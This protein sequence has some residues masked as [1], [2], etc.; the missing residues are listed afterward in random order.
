MMKK[1]APHTQFV[2]FALRGV[3]ATLELQL[4]KVKLAE[5]LEG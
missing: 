1:P 4:A 5:S 2:S 3:L